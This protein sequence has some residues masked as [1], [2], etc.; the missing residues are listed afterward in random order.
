MGGNSQDQDPCQINKESRSRGNRLA[1]Q[2]KTMGGAVDL[3]V[4]AEDLLQ[5]PGAPSKDLDIPQTIDAFQ[6]HGF[7]GAQ[8]LAVFHTYFSSRAHCNQREEEADHQIH[9][10]QYSCKQRMEMQ[11]QQQ[12][13]TG[14]EDDGEQWP[15]G[16]GKE[17]FN[18]FNIRYSDAENIALFTVNEAGRSQ[19]TE[20]AV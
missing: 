17:E 7:Q 16:M 9:R 13:H 2:G 6:N 11:C 19:G 20:G 5:T 1:V 3:L 8:T 10:Q 4:L 18:G 14:Q 15:D 12:C